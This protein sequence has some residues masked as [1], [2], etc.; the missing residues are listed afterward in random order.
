MGPLGKYVQNK[1]G[2]VE[3][4]PSQFPVKIPQLRRGKLVI[5]NHQINLVKINIRTDFIYLPL[6][7]ECTGFGASIR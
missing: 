7:D 3:N 1:I 2:A 5:K 4:L 6:P